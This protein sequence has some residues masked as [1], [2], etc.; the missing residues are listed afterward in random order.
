MRTITGDGDH[1]PLANPYHLQSG[2]LVY[3]TFLRYLQKSTESTGVEIEPKIVTVRH[4][5]HY[6]LQRFKRR[7]NVYVTLKYRYVKLAL[8]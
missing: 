6:R 4:S 7:F 1:V 8:G 5:A 2:I 3:R